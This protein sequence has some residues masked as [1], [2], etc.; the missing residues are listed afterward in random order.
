M[1]ATHRTIKMTNRNPVN[2]TATGCR[3]Q[4]VL[5]EG[6]RDFLQPLKENIEILIQLGQ[7][8]FTSHLF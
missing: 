4:A 6:A 2:K 5:T 3:R 1:Y 8:R 7:N